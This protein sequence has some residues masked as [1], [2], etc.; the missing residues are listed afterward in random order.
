MQRFRSGACL[1][2]LLLLPPALARAASAGSSANDVVRWDSDRCGALS[3]QVGHRTGS[4]GALRVASW[5]VVLARPGGGG[6]GRLHAET[7]S[8]A[9]PPALDTLAPLF[10]GGLLVGI[11][12]HRPKACDLAHSFREAAAE[13][14]SLAPGATA[15]ERWTGVRAVSGDANADANVIRL[16][17]SHDPNGTARLRAE[18]EGF[19]A[20][21]NDMTAEPVERSLV[22]VSMPFAEASRLAAGGTLGPSDVVTIDRA[23]V[24]TGDGRVEAS[25]TYTP[26]TRQGQLHVVAT[27]FDDLK[28]AL[29]V[30]ERTEAGAAFLILRMA[31]RT[32][33]DG[34]TAWDVVIDDT[35]M[36]IN[37]IPLP[38]P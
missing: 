18:T 29:P 24:E 14:A 11:E 35:H 2:I 20:A 4:P 8:T 26:T 3:V 19:S 33:D 28:N 13:L 31:G 12:E 6:G 7:L 21:G 38:L 9:G 17:A 22:A 16:E 25:G 5:T 36:T 15:S 23:T 10:A 34:A 1:A 37:G 32:T 30:A 27:D